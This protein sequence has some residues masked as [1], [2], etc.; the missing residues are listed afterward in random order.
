MSRAISHKTK[1]YLSVIVCIILLPRSRVL[2]SESFFQVWTSGLINNI[3]HNGANH[4]CFV[5]FFVFSGY[6]S[7]LTDMNGNTGIIKVSQPS[8]PSNSS[9]V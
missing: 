9:S 5:F 8:N 2:A 4:I 3:S 6:N 7:S 1:S